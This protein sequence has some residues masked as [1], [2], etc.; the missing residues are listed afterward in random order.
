VLV[1]LRGHLLLA[2]GLRLLDVH[3][4]AENRLLVDLLRQHHMAVAHVHVF[5]FFRQAGRGARGQ[6]HVGGDLARFVVAQAGLVLDQ[7]HRADVQLALAR[8]HLQ[9]A[10]L[11]RRLQHRALAL[12]RGQ[13]HTVGAPGV[14]RFRCLPLE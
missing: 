9:F 2:L 13:G 1:D 7:V 5:G 8:T 4:A 12:R 14:L 3:V 11:L 10:L 6:H